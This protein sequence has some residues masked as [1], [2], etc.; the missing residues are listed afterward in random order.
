MTTD[1]RDRRNPDRH[2][3]DDAYREE[4][5]GVVA[6]RMDRFLPE[7][8]DSKPRARQRKADKDRR[9][10]SA[11]ET[12]LA[13]ASYQVLYSQVFDTL[14]QAETAT[15]AALAAVRSLLTTETGELADMQEHANILPDGRKVYRN[16]EGETFTEDGV[17]IEGTLLDG[18]VWRDGAPTYEQIRAKR[19][20]IAAL[21][22]RTDAL[23]LYQTDVLGT[24]RNRLQ[25]EDNPPSAEELNRLQKMIVE[26]APPEVSRQ[27]SAIPATG[28][29]DTAQPSSAIGKPVL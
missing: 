9:R 23:L 4:L 12:L 21:Q 7:D 13:S 26:S 20:S 25:D 11:L 29:D 27:M 28:A 8:H 5:A 1:H 3:K 16:A 15:E 14:R 19:E 17:K 24:A 22:A 18:V 10:A 6:G 2:E